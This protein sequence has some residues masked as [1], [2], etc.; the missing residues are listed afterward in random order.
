M[1]YSREYLGGGAANCERAKRMGRGNVHLSSPHSSRNSRLCRHDTCANNTPSEPARRLS[2]LLL[3]A[4][5]FSLA[6]DMFLTALITLSWLPHQLA[7]YI[8]VK[9][10]REAQLTSFTIARATPLARGFNSL[11]RNHQKSRQKDVKS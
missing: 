4:Q 2:V 1:C 11:K 3:L 6:F 10:L 8:K 9:E 5:S 7:N